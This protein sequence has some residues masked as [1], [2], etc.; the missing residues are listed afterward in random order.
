MQAATPG[1]SELTAHFRLP[2]HV[3]VVSTVYSRYLVCP[4]SNRTGGVAHSQVNNSYESVTS[5]NSERWCFMKYPELK[6]DDLDQHATLGTGSFGRV[7]LC[8]HK[9]DG[10]FYALKILKK[11]EV[12]YLKQVQQQHAA[13][14]PRR[15]E[16]RR[17]AAALL[18]YSVPA[19][20]PRPYPYPGPSLVAPRGSSHPHSAA[21]L[22]YTGRAREDRE[23]DPRGDRPPQH[24]Q[25]ARSLPG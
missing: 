1:K 8:Q 6:L 14:G 2:S 10:K 18:D 24:R 23:E 19:S 16:P 17:A 9:D 4:V 11:T 5:K 25:H 21:L 22:P 12:L 20:T 7:R 13:C 15:T 3:H